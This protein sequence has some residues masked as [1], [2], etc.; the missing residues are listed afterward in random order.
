MHQYV[1]VVVGEHLGY[2][3]TGAWTILIAMM[4]A[5]SPIYGAPMALV[6]I[7]SAVGILLG[8]LEPAG[9]KPAGMINALSYLLWSVWLIVA[10]ILLIAWTPV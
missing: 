4:M 1:S 6:G 2:L 5:A 10:G 8:L 9:W 3:F 7:A